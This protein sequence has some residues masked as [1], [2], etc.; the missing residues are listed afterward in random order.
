MKLIINIIGIIGIL[1]CFVG[2]MYQYRA[3]NHLKNQNTLQITLINS[4]RR[5]QIE[6]YSNIGKKYLSRSDNCAVI[7]VSMVLGY[8]IFS[9]IFE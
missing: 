7:G 6:D 3:R 9:G 5:G 4:F 2:F 8:A 1:I